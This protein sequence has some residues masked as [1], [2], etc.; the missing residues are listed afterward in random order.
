MPPLGALA[1]C[2][3]VATSQII[4]EVGNSLQSAGVYQ[5]Q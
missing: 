4:A 2:E 5:I 3:G 1:E